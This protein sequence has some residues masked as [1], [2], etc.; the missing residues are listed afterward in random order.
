MEYERFR[1]KRDLWYGL[2]IMFSLSAASVAA[3]MVPEDERLMVVLLLLPVW[4]FIVSLWFLTWYE[5]REDYLYARSGP[6]VEKIPYDRI[7][8]IRESKN[9]FSSMAMSRDRIEIRQHDKGFVTGTTYI[10]PEDKQRFMGML[11]ARCYNL[12]E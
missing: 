6:F 3:F 7:R 12:Q 8:S 11:R 10:S 9:L 1:S 4:A 2:L 5:L